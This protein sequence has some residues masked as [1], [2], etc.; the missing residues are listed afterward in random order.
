MLVSTIGRDPLHW[1]RF[2]VG[3]EAT[4]AAQRLANTALRLAQ[5]AGKDSEVCF[6]LEYRGLGRHAAPPR[7]FSKAAHSGELAQEQYQ[8]S[9]FIDEL[10]LR[11]VKSRAVALA[12]RPGQEIARY[13]EDTQAD[14]VGVVAP[15]R[16]MGFLDRLLSHPIIL[17][18]DKLPCT[19]LLFRSSGGTA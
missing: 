10:D 16:A 8:L 4:A 5:Q 11:N 13:A 9:S 15:N 12:G 3:I 14:V 18:L 19:V 17:M 7:E 1:S 2:I 6:A